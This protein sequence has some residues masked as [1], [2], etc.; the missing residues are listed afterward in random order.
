M[1]ALAWRDERRHRDD[2][3]SARAAARCEPTADSR[4]HTP[5]LRDGLADER[6]HRRLEPLLRGAGGRLLSLGH[7][8]PLLTIG[9]T[10]SYPDYPA[11]CAALGAVGPRV[12][13]HGLPAEHAPFVVSIA[14]DGKVSVG[15]QDAL[16]HLGSDV[17]RWVDPSELP[18]LSALRALRVAELRRP[19]ST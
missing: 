1:Q 9:P 16:R 15:A 5:E 17:L 8:T 11:A 18:A 4:E 14:G 10:F 2:C 6:R 3:G 7:S 12:R 19:A 13:K